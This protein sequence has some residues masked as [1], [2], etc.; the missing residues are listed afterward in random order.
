MRKAQISRHEGPR[1]LP[2]QQGPE[3]G[4]PKTCAGYEGS[5]GHEEQAAKTYAQWGIDYLK[6]G[7]TI[8]SHLN[9]EQPGQIYVPHIGNHY[10]I[11]LIQRFRT[12]TLVGIPSISIPMRP[13]RLL[14]D[15]GSSSMY[16]DINWPFMT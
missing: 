11:S 7:S 3:A 1:R 9:N 12:D 15:F 16:T 10:L 5:Y 14:D 4:G 6:Y 8:R 2:P 13:E